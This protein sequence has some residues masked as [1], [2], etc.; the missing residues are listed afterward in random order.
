MFAI[1]TFR[2]DGPLKSVSALRAAEVHNS[3][4]EPLAHA[5]QGAPPPRH[6]I[7]SGN[8]IAT[9]RDR[10]QQHGL[11]LARL[12]KG[13][14]L[15]FEAILT[16]SPR[17]FSQGTQDEQAEQLDRWVAG[18]VKW[19]LARYSANRII[20][21]VLHLDESTPHVH[22]IVLPL[23]MKVDRRR[24]DR[25][26]RWNLVGSSISGPGRYDELQTQYA[27]TMSPFGLQRGERKS[28]RKHK[29][30]AIYMAELSAKERELDTRINGLDERA[31]MIAAER[32]RLEEDRA[33]FAA[34]K[35]AQDERLEASRETLRQQ[36]ASLSGT[37]LEA[38]RG[39]AKLRADRDTLRRKTAEVEALR[40][41]AE[42]DRQAAAQL[43][44]S[45]DAARAKLNEHFNL[46]R[47]VF[48]KAADVNHQIAALAG[49]SLTPAASSIAAAITDLGRTAREIAPPHDEN[50]ATVLDVYALIQRRGASLGR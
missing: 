31:A 1:A 45:N 5:I 34:A 36:A 3:R 20:S 47:P 33:K 49:K 48:R 30:T 28:G 38:L 43:L 9:T 10:L 37:R 7:G 8:L 24:R 13:G 2:D 14:V 39:E 27:S 16:A 32:D 35:T 29:P 18:Q 23:V 22:L 26:P 19:A 17:F 21:M 40:A 44:S 12:R 6:L 42:A 15:A 25:S 50:R 4:L 11:S 46:L 41:A